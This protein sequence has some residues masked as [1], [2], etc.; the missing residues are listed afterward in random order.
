MMKCHFARDCFS[1]TSIPSYQSHVQ[2]KPLH[3]SKQKPKL[4]HVKYFEAKYNKV[5]AK[6]ALLSLSASAPNSSLGKNKGLVAKTYEW[7]EEEVPSDKI[8]RTKVKALMALADE[9]RV[10]VGKESVSNGE[11]VTIFIL[12]VYTLL[13]M[14]DNDVRKSFLDYL[15]IELNYV[16]EQRNNLLSKHRNLAQELNTC[17]EQLL[18]PTQKKKILGIDQLT[19]DTSGSGPKDLVFVKPLAY[20]PNR[21]ITS[22]NKPRLSEAE[23]FILPNHDADKS[24]D[25]SLIYSTPLP[26]LE[27]LDGANL[28]SGP[29]TIKSMLKSN[30]TFKAETLKGFII[31]EPSSAPAKG[32]NYDETYAPLTKLEAI[33]IF[34]AMATY[35]NFIVYLM[36]VKSAFLNGKLKEEVYV[37]QPS[38]FESATPVV[39]KAPKPF[40]NAERVPQGI[41]PKAKP[42]HKKHSTSLKQP[43]VYNSE[44]TKAYFILHS[45]SASR[46]DA[47]VVSTAEADPKKYAP[48]D[49]IP[50]QQGMNEETKNTSYDHSF[51]DT[52]VGTSSKIS[53]STDAISS[54]KTEDDII[55]L[56]GQDGTQQAKLNVKL[57]KQQSKPTSPPTTPIIPPVITTTTTQM[58]S[59]FLQSPPKSSSQPE[60]EHIKKDNGK[61]ALSSEEAKKESTINGKRIHLTDEQINQQKKIEEEAKA[62]ATKRKS[63][64]R[65]EELV[66]LFGPEVALFY[67]DGRPIDGKGIGRKLLDKVYET[68]SIELAG[69]EFA[70]DGEKSLFTIGALLK[71][72]LEFTV[73]L[74]KQL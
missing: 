63:E 7:D 70:Y 36:D 49:F 42:G 56:A 30:S 74:E 61:K 35:M 62:E 57:T 10:Y 12:K 8:E 9:E 39:F 53:F 68:Y 46:N 29:K 64:I 31:N 60:G 43:S 6:I 48:G 41:K 20:N 17:K 19:E 52:S 21:F 28:I 51:A 5:K 4:K 73:V 69:K 40:S 50:Q 67:E 71:N 11:W 3:S 72:K 16:E 59:P 25:E 22:G 24:T 2:T 27:K 58:R 47:S 37:K 33:R 14:E 15:C 54:K 45:E 13:E 65:K 32:I 55:P 38:S 1:K 34:L 26:L 23:D 44:V 18:I 66:D